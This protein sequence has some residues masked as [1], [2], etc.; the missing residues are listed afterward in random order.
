[1]KTYVYHLFTG[2]LL[3]ALVSAGCDPT[4]AKPGTLSRAPRDGAQPESGTSTQQSISSFLFAIGQKRKEGA[5]DLTGYLQLTYTGRSSLSQVEATVTAV[6]RDGTRLE[7]KRSWPRWD[8]DERK[9]IDLDVRTDVRRCVL[10]G[11]ARVDGETVRLYSSFEESD[12]KLGPTG[13]EVTTRKGVLAHTITITNRTDA[14]LTEVE[15]TVTVWFDRGSKP[16]ARTYWTNWAPGEKKNIKV[17]A[18]GKIEKLVWS[19]TAYTH[20]KPAHITFINQ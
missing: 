10:S 15:L 8:L 3:L 1:M 16:E 5:R 11:T 13:F 6:C 4:A 18:E 9:E 17:K 14:P 12:D 20:G 2:G 7:A 19:G